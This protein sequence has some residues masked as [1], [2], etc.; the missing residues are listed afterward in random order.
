[1][2]TID[3]HMINKSI[4]LTTPDLGDNLYK[5]LNPPSRVNDNDDVIN[6]S[7]ELNGSNIFDSYYKLNIA[8]EYCN[9]SVELYDVGDYDKL[10]I[11]NKEILK[12]LF[13]DF[14]EI[15][16][17]VWMHESNAN[18]PYSR[19]YDEDTYV[20]G[21]NKEM[22]SNYLHFVAGCCLPDWDFIVWQ[23]KLKDCPRHFCGN[24]SPLTVLISVEGDYVNDAL[25]FDSFL[26]IMGYGWTP[27][28]CAKYRDP[29]FESRAMKILHWLN[30]RNKS[31][32]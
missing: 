4:E 23:G 31:V 1:M 10:E 2:K 27:E 5:L 20:V 19:Y 3:E 7:I 6:R 26:D 28:E 12:A 15:D 14:G 17:T 22:T 25:S 32:G 8:Y 21:I 24:H 11:L 30:E 18:I 9:K 16:V 29:L 13:G